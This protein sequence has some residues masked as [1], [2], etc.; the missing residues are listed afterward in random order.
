MDSANLVRLLNEAYTDSGN[1]YP[2]IDQ[3]RM[4]AWVTETLNT[5]YTVVIEKSGRLVGSLA[6]TP[7]QFP[8]S[9]EWFLNMEWFYV[10]RRFRRNA[11][12]DALL[13][14]AHGFAD[15]KDASIVGGVSSAKDATLKDRLMTMRGYTYMGGNFIRKYDNGKPIQ[16]TQDETDP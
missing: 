1:V 6:L 15:S 5:G 11:S 8:W 3:H 13:L 4:L 7:F 14:A 10:Q 2:E 12:A 16:E 9:R